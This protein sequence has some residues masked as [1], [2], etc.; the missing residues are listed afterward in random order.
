M[1]QSSTRQYGY[2]PADGV[3]AGFDKHFGRAVCAVTLNR[4]VFKWSRMTVNTSV[5]LKENTDPC[6]SIKQYQVIRE[7]GITIEFE[8]LIPEEGDGASAYV[9]DFRPGVVLDRFFCNLVNTLLNTR[10]DGTPHI[11]RYGTFFIENSSIDV[12]RDDFT[13]MR[14]TIRSQGYGNG[15]AIE[16]DG[17]GVNPN[18]YSNYS[19]HAVDSDFPS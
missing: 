4:N 5:D 16:M 15:M 17:D 11:N 9:M 1:A 2:A 8:S 6:S 3:L 13:S 12:S 19:E 18:T 10:P 14:M 7:E